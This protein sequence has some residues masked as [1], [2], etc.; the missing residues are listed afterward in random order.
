[1]PGQLDSP[2]TILRRRHDRMEVRFLTQD[3][4]TERIVETRYKT[5]DFIAT[6][7]DHV[8][9][10]YRHTVRYFGLMSPRN[11]RSADSVFSILGQ[12]QLGKPRRVSWA[13]SLQRCFSANPLVDRTGQPMRWTRRLLNR[14]A[15]SS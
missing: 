15:Q 1:M 11:K 7:A 9:D 2:L 8:P 13:V 10:R 4:R 5:A 12:Q 14:S 6:L 3:T